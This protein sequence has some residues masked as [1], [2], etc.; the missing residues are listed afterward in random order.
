M[1]RANTTWWLFGAICLALCAVLYVV[2]AALFSGDWVRLG[3][4][5]VAAIGFAVGAFGF[6]LHWTKQRQSQAM[7]PDDDEDSDRT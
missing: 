7:N 5:V 2:S 1:K 6:Y 3:L 4:S